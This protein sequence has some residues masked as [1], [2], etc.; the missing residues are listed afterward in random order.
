MD[1]RSVAEIIG[2]IAEGFEKTCAQ[3]LSDNKRIVVLAIQ[4]Q[5]Y[6][7]RNGTGAYLKPTYDEDP[8]FNE[9]GHWKGKSAQYKAW[10]QKITPPQADFILPLGLT[11]RPDSVPNLYISGRFYEEITA[12]MSGNVLMTDPGGGCGPDIVSKYGEEILMIGD[13]AVG[14]FNENYM[15][16][17]IESLFER[18]G[19]K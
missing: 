3:C 9:E 5:L 11:A 2:R 18:S 6:T 12:Q 4:E 13:S 8:F 16:P 1:I 17:A 19:Y 10:K 15:M 14:Y 7:G